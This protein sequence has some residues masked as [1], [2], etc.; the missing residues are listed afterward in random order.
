MNS[1]GRLVALLLL[2][3]LSC[4]EVARSQTNSCDLEVDFSRP[5]GTIRHLNDVNGGPLCERGWVDLSPSYKELGIKYVRLNDVAWTFDDALNINYVFPRF[6]ADAGP[7]G[8]LRLFSDRLVPESR[9][10]LSA[11]RSFTVSVPRQSIPSC[12]PGIS[13]LPRT[14]RNGRRSA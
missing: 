12:L 9:S 7:A 4:R 11:S 8:Q 2:A 13:I 14:L 1:P 10:R 6:E 3:G 5:T